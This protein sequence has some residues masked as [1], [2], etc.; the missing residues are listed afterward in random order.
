MMMLHKIKFLLCHTRLSSSILYFTAL[1]IST[2]LF[3]KYFKITFQLKLLVFSN[4]IVFVL[5]FRKFLYEIQFLPTKY[6]NLSTYF[7]TISTFLCFPIH[8]CL[9]KMSMSSS[10]RGYISQ[11][12]LNLL[13]TSLYP[14]IQ[15]YYLMA[16][17]YW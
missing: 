8:C 15:W 4:L 10:Q 1:N 9:F 3:W 5:K 7:N 14:I 2:G 11:C 12:Y 17:I 13:L 16:Y 6:F